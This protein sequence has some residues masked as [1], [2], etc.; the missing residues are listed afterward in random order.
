[1]PGAVVTAHVMNRAPIVGIVR[2]V[3]SSNERLSLHR[4]ARVRFAVIV[5]GVD[6]VERNLYL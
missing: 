5:D 6:V 3:S 2:A 1:M 4:D